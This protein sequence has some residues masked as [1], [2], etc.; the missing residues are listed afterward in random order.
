VN[1]D[2]PGRT[3]DVVI[4]GGGIEGAAAAWALT[5][6]DAGTVIV[7]ERHTVAS[8]GTGKSSGI[9]RC[10]Y[11]V[12]SLAAMAWAG[13]QFFEQ[14]PE[15]LGEDIGFHRTGYVVG[16]GEADVAALH[17]NLAM[18]RSVGVEVDLI[19]PDDVA[20]LWPPA[21]VDD[22]AAFGYEPRGGFGDGYRTAQALAAAARRAGA[23]V[24]QNATVCEILLAGDRVRGVRLAGGE[25]I[26][27]RSV[28]VAAGPWSVPLLG[29][30]G[31]PLP[32]TAVREEILLID[33]GRELPPLP[34]LSDLVSLQYIRPE[35]GGEI[36]FGNSDHSVPRVADPDDYSDVPR[37]A[38][39]DAAVEKL[40]H[41][42]PGLP[43]A[44]IA[45]GY[46]GCYDVTPDWNPV[47]SLTPVEGLVVAAGFSGHGFKIAPAVGAL[48]A[49]LVCTGRS[50][51]P[52]VDEADFR[53]GRFAEGALLRSPH[54]YAGAGQ[55][56]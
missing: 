3:A 4:V 25:E 9:V 17:A 21:R 15:L 34:V 38:A 6:R 48:V 40:A 49:D 41:R 28:V 36:L 1:E 42:F 20:Q 54:P 13:V 2:R 56:R 8:A 19:G 29:A 47:I 33:P 37:P 51:E 52:D 11:G 32:V 7:L 39:V 53:L 10:H 24:R 55:M 23:A 26:H 50:S 22:F 43:D 44:S 14:A 27:S 18:Q 5:R 12:R 45:G 30:I 31:V 16:V 35:P 46:A